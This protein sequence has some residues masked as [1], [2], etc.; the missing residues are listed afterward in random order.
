MQSVIVVSSTRPEMRGRVLGVL[1]VAIGSG[2][3]GALHVGRLATHIGTD[4]A[5]MAI[6]VVGFVLT[7][8][9]VLATVSSCGAFQG[10]G[11]EH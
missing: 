1:A 11:D 10:I 6:A 3:I 9:T 4:T 2:P 7:A 8:G 5:V